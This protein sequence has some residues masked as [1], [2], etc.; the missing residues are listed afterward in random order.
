MLYGI[1]QDL[2]LNQ[3][4]YLFLYIIKSRFIYLVTIVT[5]ITNSCG[6]L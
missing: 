1:Y 3:I 4:V 2:L 6:S 5:S